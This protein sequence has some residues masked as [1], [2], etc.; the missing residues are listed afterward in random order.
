M[1]FLHSI[2]FGLG[3]ALTILAGASFAQE[4]SFESL[5][6]AVVV[7]GQYIV[8]KDPGVE[9][10]ALQLGAMGEGINVV[11]TLPLIGAQVVQLEEGPDVQ[12]LSAL[13]EDIPGV[14]YIEPV[15]EL[16]ID[17]EPNDPRYGEQWG[18]P[19]IK[20]PPAWDTRTD[21]SEFVVA[22]I[23]TGVD[24]RHPDLAA[25]MW[26]NP[27]ET[28][29]N[30]LD[31]DNNGVVDDV[32]GA[33]FVPSNTTGDPADDHGH[34]TH[35]GG[36]VGAV[37]ENNLGVAGTGWSASLMAL[38]FLNENGSGSTAGAIRAIEYAIRMEA[39]VMN[40]SWGGGGKSQALAE[41]IEAAN[42]AGILFVAA[43][44][45][46]NTDNDSQPHYP[47][48]YDVPN[49]LAVMATDQ[50]DNRAGF[51]SFGA[52][53]V[54]V[55]AP[56]TSILSTIP[57][58]D[59]RAFNGTSMATPHVSGAAALV[60]AQNPSLNHLEVKDRLMQTADVVPG[61]SG[62][63]VTGARIN[64]AAA[65]DPKKEPEPP[66]AGCDSAQ[67]TQIAYEESYWS[68]QMRADQNTNLLSVSFT[69]P[70]QMIVD[71]AAHGSGRRV[72]GSGNTIAR[73]GVYNQQSVNTMWTGSY[74]RAN[75]ASADDNKTLSSDFSIVLPKGDHTIYW[76]LWVSNATIQ[77][78]SG[79]LT[80]RGIP[81]SMGGKLNLAVA[82]DA[83]PA[84][85]EADPSLR[86]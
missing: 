54:D 64:L 58:G 25:N 27:G 29:G 15:Y 71:I 60:W 70:E 53:S 36:T 10:Q 73:T 40:N 16:R 38:K 9:F 48:S 50:N 44:G 83:D 18:F 43:A 72:S 59:Y 35:V 45:N 7:P 31:D 63:S 77:L 80:V 26:Q 6:E 57:G 74:R 24:Y 67:H 17:V 34:G 75:F 41:A 69:L 76:K 14:L 30:G 66:T 11:S 2:R 21:S 78:D 61:L 12:S 82:A 49:V 33:N 55:G 37:S 8:K 84:I 65:I 28:P 52:T 3:G 19:Q 62:T 79:T 4:A 23:D 56:G 51:S 81:C 46:S 1:T 47:S 68:E 85:T 22:I 42:D 32:F 5:T 13:A 39:D 20:A 86:P